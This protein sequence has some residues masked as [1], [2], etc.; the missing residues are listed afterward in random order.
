MNR[1]EKEDKTIWFIEVNQYSEEDESKGPKYYDF[2]SEE[3]ENDEIIDNKSSRKSSRRLLN[4]KP[5]LP[6]GKKNVFSCDNTN[7]SSK[8]S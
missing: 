8:K 2:E 6:S 4:L 7:T 5:D 1:R 3:S